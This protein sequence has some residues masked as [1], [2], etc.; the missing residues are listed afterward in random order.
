MLL[1]YYGV[2][3]PLDQLIAECNTTMIGCSGKDLMLAGRNHGLDM[4]GWKTDAEAVIR[5][6]RPAIVWWR[7]N[8]WV[9]FCGLDE[10]GKVVICNPDKG[11]YRMSQ[12]TFASFYTNICLTNGEP[13]EV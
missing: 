1:E 13:N 9:V 8:H 7:F 11:R 2:S 4:K 12:G 5:Q 10:N 3:V 6:D